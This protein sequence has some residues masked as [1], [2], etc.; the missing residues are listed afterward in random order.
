[1]VW[2]LGFRLM[3]QPNFPSNCQRRVFAQYQGSTCCRALNISESGKCLESSRTSPTLTLRQWVSPFKVI[4]LARIPVYT[5]DLEIPNTLVG[6]LTERAAL[7]ICS[8]EFPLC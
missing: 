6:Q 7:R 1:M 8:L 2:G 3:G 4:G 5:C